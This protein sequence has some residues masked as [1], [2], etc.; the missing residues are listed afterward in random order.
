MKI[1]GYPIRL[2]RNL[3]SKETYNHFLYHPGSFNK[4]WL[5]HTPV[6]S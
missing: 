5:S 2:L 1:V 3:G 4:C 6:I